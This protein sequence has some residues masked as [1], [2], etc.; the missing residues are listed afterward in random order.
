[1]FT[2]RG[3]FASTHAVRRRAYA[4]SDYLPRRPT[5]TVLHAPVRDHL[6]PFLDHAQLNYARGLPRYVE[7]AFRDYL[8]CGVFA[9]GFQR[10]HCDDGRRDLLVAF[11]FQ[12]VAVSARA[13]PDATWRTPPRTSSI[14]S[15]PPSRADV[16]PALDRIFIE[17]VA[18]E[19]KRTAGIGGCQH[20]A[21]N[22][23]QRFGGSLNLNLH[24]HAII[25]DGVFATNEAGHIYFHAL[26][27]PT[28]DCWSASSGASAIAAKLD[29]VERAG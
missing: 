14:A 5:E 10:L 23:V 13:A 18:L 22:H 20:A 3:P 17:A 1:M 8:T 16:A 4:A 27:P 24:F 29:E 2:D 25:A 12:G 9:H 15:F 6:E 28:R 19:R 26:A 11:S 7:Q 21:V